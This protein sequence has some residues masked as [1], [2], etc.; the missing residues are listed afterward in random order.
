MIGNDALWTQLQSALAD[1]AAS[2]AECARLREI[3]SEAWDNCEQCRGLTVGKMR[4]AR[5]QTFLAAL[6]AQPN[7]TTTHCEWKHGEDDSDAWET[8][9]GEMFCLN[10]GTPKENKVCFCPYCGKPLSEAAQP[11]DAKQADRDSAKSA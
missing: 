7:G 1:L 11:N 4:C 5:C 9:C 6:A 10:T 3:I 8:A 2:Q